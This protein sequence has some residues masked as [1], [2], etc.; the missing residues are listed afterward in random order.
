M[1]S[2]WPV[3]FDA[4]EQTFAGRD[5]GFAD[6]TLY[7]Q[8]GQRGLPQRLLTGPKSTLHCPKLTVSF[9]GHCP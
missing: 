6:D 8:D 1:V 9:R 3:G 4:C 5:C 7:Q 2:W